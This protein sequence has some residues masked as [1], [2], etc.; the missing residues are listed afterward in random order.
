MTTEGELAGYRIALP[1]VAI[2]TIGAGGGS[3]VGVDARGC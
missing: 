1:M 3:I 2:H